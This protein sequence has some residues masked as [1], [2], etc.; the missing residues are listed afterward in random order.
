MLYLSRNKGECINLRLGNELVT[1]KLINATNDFAHISIKASENV[2][3][4]R[5]NAHK[6]TKKRPTFPVERC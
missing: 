5:D 1:I 4:L 2:H 6:K 3:I